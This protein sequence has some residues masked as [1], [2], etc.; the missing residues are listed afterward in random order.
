MMKTMGPIRVLVV[1]SAF[2]LVVFLANTVEAKDNCT[3]VKLPDWIDWRSKEAR[4]GLPRERLTPNRTALVVTLAIF[5][6]LTNALLCHLILW[7]ENIWDQKTYKMI[8]SL[9]CNDC[10]TGILLGIAAFIEVEGAEASAPRFL[11]KSVIAG[12]WLCV[13]TSIYT[14]TGIS[15]IR[16]LMLNH[17]NFYAANVGNKPTWCIYMCIASCWIAGA[18]HALPLLTSWNNEC[19]TDFSTCSLPYKS[20]LWIWGA[21]IFVLFIPS[22]V[23]VVVYTLILLKMRD[24]QENPIVEQVTKTMSI[25]TAAFLV[26]WW[27]LGIYLSVR[28]NSAGGSRGFYWGALSSLVNPILVI[29]LNNQLYAKVADK[30]SSMFAKVKCCKT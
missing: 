23:I 30:V 16:W 14:F 29:Y 24:K 25:L 5:I 28:W 1:A 20:P 19:V 26:C 3:Q 4:R 22:L 11:C 7:D 9:A 15:V 17:P 21:A 2:V 12:L 6:V 18:L 27:P 13:V 10:I 8:F